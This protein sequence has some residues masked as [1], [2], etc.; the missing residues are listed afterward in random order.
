[1]PEFL[2][3]VENENHLKDSGDHIVTDTYKPKEFLDFAK[4]I[5]P[6]WSVLPKQAQNKDNFRNPDANQIT[7]TVI[8][9]I[10]KEFKNKTKA[11]KKHSQNKLSYWGAL[12]ETILD[13]YTNNI[14]VDKP[15][16]RIHKNDFNKIPK[17]CRSAFKKQNDWYSV[18]N[19]K[20]S[21]DKIS[22]VFIDAKAEQQFT[23]LSD[24][25][26]KLIPVIYNKGVIESVSPESDKQIYAFNRLQK[27][28]NIII[29]LCFFVKTKSNVND[30]ISEYKY[31][32]TNKDI[33]LKAQRHLRTAQQ[34]VVSAKK[35]SEI[36][37]DKYISETEARYKQ[38][39]CEVLKLVRN[40]IHQ[41]FK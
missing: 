29:N 16:K 8:K 39:K 14:M 28:F 15:T 11:L 26:N 41:H 40:T 30:V 3:N 13:F 12:F 18:S 35:N 32:K 27:I 20:E 33:I 10:E 5:W 17:Y 21:G 1:M 2:Q 6:V 19:S 9:Q 37:N 31:A 34:L 23:E 25:A 36:F 24:E 22:L 4:V 38:T 7:A